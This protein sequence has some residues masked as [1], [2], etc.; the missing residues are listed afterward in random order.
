MNICVSQGDYTKKVDDE[1]NWL[2][3]SFLKNW[4]PMQNKNFCDNSIQHFTRK[5]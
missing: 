1:M 3:I 5:S 4:L 2:T